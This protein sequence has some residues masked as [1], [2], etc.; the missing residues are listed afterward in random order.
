MRNKTIFLIF[1]LFVGI[2]G[3]ASRDDVSNLQ[4]DM[5][6]MKTRFYKMEKDISGIRAEAREG[7]DNTAKNF[8]SEVESLRKTVADLQ[9]AQDVARVD[10]QSL[11]GKLDD[12]KLQTQKPSEEMAILKEDTDRRLLALEGK[13][14]TQEKA[15]ADAKPQEETPE[16]LYGE[17]MDA[18]KKGE[19]K[20]SREAFTKFTAQY[21]KHA[22]AAESHYWIGDTYYN[23][24]NLEQAILEYQEVIKNPSGK[25]K[26]PAAMLKQAMA[27]KGLGDDKS[28]RY[29][30]KKL[31]EDYPNSEEAKKAK[32]KLKGLK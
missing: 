17:A 29:I 10:M 22:L 15:P 30:Y 21:P 19:M 7:T 18:F 3:C 28:A 16:S 23:E 11:S 26:A 24:K 12:I 8:Q 1:G 6:E 2:A 20:K 9:A 5:E 14:V 32:E 27:F 25:G 13:V 4:Q 31:I